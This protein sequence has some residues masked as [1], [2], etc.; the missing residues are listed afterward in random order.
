MTS[1]VEAKIRAVLNRM[2][3]GWRQA[4]P[5]LLQGAFDP[6]DPNISLIVPENHVPLYG[7]AAI[8]RYFDRIAAN[9]PDVRVEL[10]DLRMTQLG[11]FTHVFSDLLTFVIMPDYGSEPRIFQAKNFLVRAR[12]TIVLRKRGEEWYV[13]HYHE[14]VPWE[15]PTGAKW[16]QPV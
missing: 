9:F 1:E 4:N 14:S 6:E 15:P 3:E 8:N 2:V 12:A 10:K 7:Q 13:V 11:E 5:R 16:E